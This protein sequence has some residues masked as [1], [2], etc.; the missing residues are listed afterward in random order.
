MR[1]HM[2]R[3][4]A[5]LAAC[6]GVLLTPA[7]LASG[8]KS[9]T[10]MPLVLEGDIVAG[11][12]MVTR[13]DNLAVNNH[14]QW[15]VEA[16][17]DHPNPD[18][19]SVLTNNGG[20]FLRE[21]A[22]VS[23]PFGA[24]IDSFDSVTINEFSRGGYN[25]FLDGTSGGN[26]DSGVHW[27]FDPDKGGIE[28]ILLVVQESQEAPGLSEGTPFIGFFDVKINNTDQFFVT[29]SVD[30][31]NIPTSVDRAL[32]VLET[33]PKVGGIA[34]YVL[35]AAEGDILPGQREP[36]AD[37][38]TGPHA[39]AFNDLGQ[40]LLFADL[41]GSTA[42]D[43]TIYLYD[44]GFTLLAQEGSA[45]PVTGR[46]WLSLSGPEMDLNNHTEYV[47]SG[48]L[49]GDA[50]TN[51][52]IVKN[53]EKFIQEGD[54]LPAIGS[55]FTFTS[56]GSGPIEIS[57]SGDVLWYGDW[58]DPNTDTDT[59][60]FLE[61]TL[62][63]QEGVTAING[64]IV[65]TLRG[66]TDGYHMSND[67]RFI[68]FEAVL[69]DGIEG[70]FLIEFEAACPWDLDGTDSVGV[71][72]LLALLAAWG[73]CQK[74]CVPPTCDFDGDCTIGITDVLILIANWG[75]CP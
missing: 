28:G 8:P 6:G 75:D 45:S 44:G 10:I 71:L 47:F 22:M 38:G 70:A 21:N 41:A 65:D 24:A 19:D 57:E 27:L 50:A 59:G 3:T 43:G 30:D 9:Y 37:F 7:S 58:D 55:V 11:V 49:D 54:T 29:A 69:Q 62:L 63:V 51:L 46:N 40:V 1:F 31:P 4:S 67:G 26:D 5:A 15:V 17:T 16:D 60:L 68:V 25:F 18:A 56:F 52:L 48:S 14:G 42:T 13:I 66:I 36:A 23:A 33:D 35:V 2:I 73:P 72:D 61:D 32:Y 34:D 20:M 12:G 64:D 74:W 39:S 53:G